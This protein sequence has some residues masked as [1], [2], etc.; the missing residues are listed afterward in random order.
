VKPYYHDDRAGITIYCGDCREVLPGLETGSV[1]LVLTD[2]PYGVNFRGNGW[3]LSIPDWLPEARRIARNVLF[4]TGQTTLWDYPRPDWVLNWQ[5]PAAQSRAVSGGFSHWT[6]ILLY[7]Q[8][9]F[10]VD[11][12]RL[13][14]MVVGNSHTAA[15]VNHPSPKPLALFEW[16][17]VHGSPEGGSV[18]DPF[19]G[20]GTTLKAAKELNR[21]AVGI[22]TC[23]EYC[24]LAANRLSQEVLTFA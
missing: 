7:G 13:H 8:A 18:L 6:P 3:D 10:P 14:A 23:E 1:D 11:C 21:R 4:T 16:L 24:E 17:T 2:P 22:D 19:M 12:F 9:K 5:R 15:H 20:S